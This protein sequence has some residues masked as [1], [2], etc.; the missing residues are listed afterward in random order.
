MP[1]RDFRGKTAI[2]GIGYGRSPQAP[3]AFTTNSG[4]S[5]LTLAVR[6]TKEACEDAGIDPKELDGVVSFQLN[7]SVPPSSVL[8]ALGCP[9]INYSSDLNGG[10]E[11]ASFAIVQAA[12]AVYHGISNYC[13]VYRA[14]NG[15]SGVRMG[16][17][18][19]GTGAGTGRVGGAGQFTSIYGLAGPPSFFAFQAQ[20]Y[21]ALY[22]VTSLDFANF[23]INR[24]TNATNNPRAAMRQP[25][26][27][28]EHQ[29]S[30]MIVHPYHLLDCCLETDVA[31][32]MVI[33]TTERVRH[34]KKKTVTISAGM[35]A[36]SF[37]D[38]IIDTGLIH[39]GPRILKAAGIKLKDIDIFEPYDNFTDCPMR[40]IEDMGWCKRGQAKDFIK[41]GRTSLDGELPILTQGGLTN[42][43]YC[44]GLNN[45]LEAVQ[46]LRGEAEDLCPDWR[47]G[48]HTYD[49][50]ICR[51]VR[52]PE[53]ALHCGVTGGSAIIFRRE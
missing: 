29:S 53:I 45:A 7:D 6:A 21:M 43:G 49:R 16:Q 39:I 48:S 20:R 22:K 27:I 4:V 14:M 33:T 44:H 38:E 13:L 10:G 9:K 32:A 36:S 51:Q 47:N 25:L 26:T 31:C 52:N 42:E 19:E 28:E 1:E 5:V 8:T 3:G 35:G 2:A 46:Q 50:N 40:L 24:R 41:D 23:C 30:R 17:L 12:Q 11:Y 37:A 18:G 15:R 34:L